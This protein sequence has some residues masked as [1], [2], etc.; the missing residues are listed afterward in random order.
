MFQLPR[1]AVL[2][3]AVL[4]AGAG[5]S[6]AL[7]QKAAPAR[8][9]GFNVHRVLS[10]PA[11]TFWRGGAPRKDTLHALAASAKARG[12]RVTLVD[13]RSPARPDDQSGKEGRLSPRDEAALAAKLGM[14]YVA[15]SAMDHDLVAV[16]KQGLEQGDVYMHCMYGVNRT[17]YAAARYATATKCSVDRSGLGSKDWDQGKAFQVRQGSKR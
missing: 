5:Y 16:L 7:A 14:K 11:G 1:A 12:A 15:V 17:G 3:L 4:L 9:P 6:P 10:G 2:S 13:L 8:P